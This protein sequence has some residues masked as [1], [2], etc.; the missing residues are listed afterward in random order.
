MVPVGVS[1]C[2][3]LLTRWVT[4]NNS[5]C[6]PA[7][8]LVLPDE[9]HGHELERGAHQP[10]ALELWGAEEVPS[11]QMCLEDPR[12]RRRDGMLWA[13]PEEAVLAQTGA[14][15]GGGGLESPSSASLLISLLA[16]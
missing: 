8:G 6:R 9:P 4:R 12:W 10:G 16:A 3:R 15:W 14:A 11:R 13:Q 5:S 7:P 2:V 1:H